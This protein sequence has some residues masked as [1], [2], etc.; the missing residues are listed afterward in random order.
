M[1]PIPPT[2]SDPSTSPADASVSPADAAVAPAGE[3]TQTPKTEGI[4]KAMLD[5][6]TAK[7]A[8]VKQRPSAAGY[9]QPAA[10]QQLTAPANSSPWL[11]ALAIVALLLAAAA[12]VCAIMIWQRMGQMEMQLQINQQNN[13]STAESAKTLARQAIS[14]SNT[15]EGQLAHTNSQLQTISEQSSRVDSLVQYINST[16]MQTQS[17]DLRAGLEL[18]QL[19]SQLTG[20]VEPLLLALKTID[21]RLQQDNQFSPQSALRQ[22]IALDMNAIR[23]A[24][25]PDPVLLSEQ[26]SDLIHKADTMPL[27]IDMFYQGVMPQ[28]SADVSSTAVEATEPVAATPSA[29]SP[30]S[31]SAPAAGVNVTT[32]SG[33]APADTVSETPG[34]WRRSWNWVADNTAAAA[35]AVWDKASSLIHVIP[36][37]HPDAV[38]LSPDQGIILRENVK[39]QLLNLRISIQ[40]RQYAQAQAEIKDLQTTITRYYNLQSPVVKDVLTRLQDLLPAVQNVTLPQPEETLRAFAVLSTHN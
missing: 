14:A 24:S 29:T 21:D 10:A 22:A 1:K 20:S 25:V 37:Q 18:A 23:N 32:E 38:L 39:L 30:S 33:I 7:P 11:G 13:N 27:M 28:E 16:R 4:S 36:I 17:A 15:L 3:E 19:Q 5:S 2:P 9:T 6:G 8:E 26:I 34:F 31:D 40:Q 12:A 35:S